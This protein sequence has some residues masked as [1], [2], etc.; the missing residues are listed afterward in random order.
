MERSPKPEAGPR[1]RAAVARVWVGVAEC[2]VIAPRILKVPKGRMRSVTLPWFYQLL[3]V[4]ISVI[5]GKVLG[6][7]VWLARPCSSLVAIYVRRSGQQRSGVFVLRV[8][9]DFL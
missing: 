3:S 7:W 5:S 4:Q 6:V 1:K 2:R 8:Q 9:G